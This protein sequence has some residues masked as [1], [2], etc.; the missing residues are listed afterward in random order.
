MCDK[1]A[2]EICSENIERFD[3][4][5]LLLFASLLEAAKYVVSS[6]E[7]VLPLLLLLLLVLLL[8][9]LL[10]L[11]LL[12]LLLLLLFLIFVLMSSLILGRVPYSVLYFWELFVY[13]VLN[14]L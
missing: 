8:V 10:L 11:L 9:L 13:L 5:S 7:L 3:A 14:Y 6:L 12:I 4:I 2:N 1:I